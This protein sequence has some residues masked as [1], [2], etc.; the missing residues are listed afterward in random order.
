ME[1]EKSVLKPGNFLP[2]EHGPVMRERFDRQNEVIILQRKHVDFVF[3]GDSLTEAWNLDTCFGDSDKYRVNRGIGGDRPLLIAKRFEADALQL[4]PDYIHLMA[5]IN[6]TWV[7]DDEASQGRMEEVIDE[8]KVRILAGLTT[9]L[10]MAAERGMKVVLASIVPTNIPLHRPGSPTNRLRNVMLLELNGRLRE[11]ALKSDLIY[12]DYHAAMV[13][14]DG[15][16]L[17]EELTED[18]IH[19]REAGYA[20]LSSVMKDTLKSKGIAV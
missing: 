16:S 10:D 7:L 1:N 6:E 17:R 8:A 14:E 18:G 3:I 9:M 5:G 20:V 19:L 13:G 15:I 11:I 2:Y 4:K 12:V